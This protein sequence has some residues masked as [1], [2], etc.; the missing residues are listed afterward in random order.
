MS[1]KKRK[2]IPA[3]IEGLTANSIA[4]IAEKLIA[5]RL[6]DIEEG[7]VKN[8]MGTIGAGSPKLPNHVGEITVQIGEVRE[9]LRELHDQI[10]SLTTR[11]TPVCSK[12]LVGDGMS[13]VVTSKA[14]MPP[15]SSF[16]VDI[17]EAR[18]A[19]TGAIA[20]IQQLQAQIAI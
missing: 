19:V 1:T 14:A 16:G 8:T 20:R 17:F 2:T 3:P 9:L 11:L 18:M 10:D 5:Q 6:K 15:V 7:R 13:P 4:E 12:E